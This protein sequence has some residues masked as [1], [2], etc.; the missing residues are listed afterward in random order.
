MC[1][2]NEITGELLREVLTEVLEQAAFILTV[3]VERSP[4]WP[5][6]VLQAEVS[7]TGPHTGRL[8]LAASVPF[9]LELAAN[10]LGVESGDPATQ[11]IARDA[12]GEVS[13]MVT[14][15]LVS[16]ISANGAE[17]EYGVPSV[18]LVGP[19]RHKTLLEQ[20]SLWVTVMSEETQQRID[21]ALAF[22][23]GTSDAMASDLSEL[24]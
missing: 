13:N 8:I 19:G 4:N 2:L 21:L 7:I 10:I 23:T 12:L 18:R 20:S 6:Y 17:F 14:G 3:Q 15:T 9:A 16:R 1:P 5:D 24:K 22:V 11:Q